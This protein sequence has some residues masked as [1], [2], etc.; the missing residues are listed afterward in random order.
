MARVEAVFDS[1]CV[2]GDPSHPAEYHGHHGEHDPIGGNAAQDLVRGVRE[3]VE[4]LWV[5]GQ[6]PQAK[7]KVHQ[8][9]GQRGAKAQRGLGFLAI[10]V[11]PRHLQPEHRTG[12][13]HEGGGCRQGRGN[14]H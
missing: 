7:G 6:D 8:G 5:A 14:Q 1:G 13:P 2:Q 11:A 4:V 3:V 12:H 10:R 9:V